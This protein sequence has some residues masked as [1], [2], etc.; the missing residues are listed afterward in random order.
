MIN[1]KESN[2]CNCKIGS[3]FKPFA[4]NKKNILTCK[5]KKYFDIITKEGPILL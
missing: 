2:I 1:I 5:N 3:Y 4:F